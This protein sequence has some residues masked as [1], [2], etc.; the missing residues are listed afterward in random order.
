[1]TDRWGR[2]NMGTGLQALTGVLATRRMMNT[3]EDRAAEDEA[4]KV[5]DALSRGEDVSGFDPKARLK[6]S[7]LYFDNMVDKGLAERQR[8]ITSNAGIEN[9]INKYKQNLADLQQRWSEYNG[10]VKLGDHD[11]AKKVAKR[12]V[13]ENMYNGYNV[14]EREGG[15][16]Y[17]VRSLAT[18]AVEKI[19]DIPI[20][21]VTEFLGGYMN[22]THDEII[23]HSLNAEQWRALHNAEI[24]KNKEVWTN[25]KGQVIYKVPAG[26]VD[27]ITGKYKSEFFVDA[28]GNPVRDAN[29]FTPMETAKGLADIAG[30]KADTTQKGLENRALRQGLE[31]GTTVDPS[32]IVSQ[33]GKQGLVKEKVGGPQFQPIEGGL[34]AS[35][36]PG[37]KEGGSN[38]NELVKRLDTE[39]MPFVEKGQSAIDPETLQITN[40]GRNAIMSAIKLVQKYQE[41]PNSLTAQEN[42]VINNAVRAVQIYQSISE[43]NRQ[44]F[45]LP[46]SPASQARP[47]TPQPPPGFVMD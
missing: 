1:M 33:G 12:M 31:M 3:Q 32:D 28:N 7:S 23:Q 6:G 16:G 18:G 19:D 10:L 43:N 9:K 26:T 45:G 41:N 21:K 42:A 29:G 2:M 40:D 13:N 22:M 44:T 46:E 11:A 8:F 38:F 24:M 27:P 5:A 20:E 34:D 25:D 47:R 37:G 14:E 15:T 39:L 35:S 30:K 4:F 17:N 36:L